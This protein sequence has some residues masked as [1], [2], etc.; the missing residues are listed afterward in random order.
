MPVPL[1]TS[2]QES[3]SGRTL[4]WFQLRVPALPTSALHKK[5]EGL[6]SIVKTRGNSVAVT[7]M[8]IFLVSWS[9]NAEMNPAPR[10]ARLLGRIERFRTFRLAGLDAARLVSTWWNAAQL[11]EYLREAQE[12][13][14]TLVIM[15]VRLRSREQHAWLPQD[16][17]DWIE[18]CD[19]PRLRRFSSGAGTVDN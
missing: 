16:A 10:Q 19:P 12:E 7:S 17:W 13:G 1:G 2:G 4:R 11:G 15:R 8:S 9:L 3:Y 14:D 6:A 18:Q 5:G